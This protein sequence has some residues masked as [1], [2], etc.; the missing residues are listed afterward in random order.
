M[1]YWL[2][3]PIEEFTDKYKCKSQSTTI[4]KTEP[5]IKT[6]II[7]SGYGAA[8]AALAIAEELI[9][10]NSKDSDSPNKIKDKD[11]VVFEKGDEYVPGD[12]PKSMGELPGHL[13]ITVEDSNDSGLLKPGEEDVL[14]NS[15]LWDIRVGDGATSIAANGLGGTSLVNAGVAMDPD[16][17]I[18]ELWPKP[19][20]QKGTD[21]ENSSK[22]TG[23]D[24][25][26]TWPTLYNDHSAKI[27]T[28]LGVRENTDLEKTG[29]FKA[30]NKLVKAI[31]PGAQAKAAPLTINFEDNS[32]QSAK[33]TKCNL[34]GNCVMGCHSG[35]KGSL[36]LNAWPLARQ[37]GVELYTGAS[38]L[39][40][41]Q[42]NQE[43]TDNKK[44]WEITIEH[45]NNK[46]KTFVVHAQRI[47]LAAGTIGSTEILLR[48]KDDLRLSD[49]LGQR[50]STNGDALLFGVGQKEPV[51][52]VADIPKPGL[53]INKVGT[54]IT[55]VAK[56]DLTGLLEK[57]LKQSKK[58]DNSYKN[59]FSAIKKTI[60]LE[61]SAVPYALK[62]IWNEIIVTQSF[63]KRY[64][65]DKRSA[66][67]SEIEK[68][69]ADF[70][71]LAISNDLGRHSQV[72]L[73]MGHDEGDGILKAKK[74]NG[75]VT[76]S[77]NTTDKENNYYNALNKAFNSKTLETGFE[78]G[79][80]HPNIFWKP[81]PDGFDG[82]LEGGEKFKNQILTVHPLGGCC[83]GENAQEGVVN[84]K[85]QVFK[86][87]SGTEVYDNLYVLDGSIIPRPIGT[88]PF[89]TIATVS[90]ALASRIES[91]SESKLNKISQM[92]FPLLE[93]ET[94]ENFYDTPEKGYT[95]PDETQTNVDAYFKERMGR[96]FKGTSVD[97]ETIDLKNPL[98]E[99]D[100]FK[101]LGISEQKIKEIKN[102]E[103][104]KI[105][106][107]SNKQPKAS[108]FV[109][110][111]EFFYDDHTEQNNSLNKWLEH[112]GSALR[113]QAT[114]YLDMKESIQTWP[115]NHLLKL[116]KLQGEVTLG[117]LDKQ[118][119]FEKTKRALSVVINYVRMRPYDLAVVLREFFKEKVFSSKFK[120][121][122]YKE[123]KTKKNIIERAKGYWRVAKLHA[124]WRVMHYHFEHMPQISPT[125]NNELSELESK[126]SKLT[127]SGEK[128]L[129]FDCKSKNIWDALFYLPVKL[130][131]SDTGKEVDFDLRIDR[132]RI[133]KGPSPLQISKSLHSPNSL[134]AIF[135]MGSYFFRA[136]M[137]TYFWSFG[138][139]NYSTFKTKEDLE[140]PIGNSNSRLADP[141]NYIH[142]GMGSE[143]IVTKQL[144]EKSRKVEM[145]QTQVGP[146]RLLR[147][148]PKS[149]DP[150]R[151]SVLLIHGLAHSSRVFWT[152]S[153]RT[154]FIQYLLEK[155]YDVW[156]V[157][158]RV[159]ANLVKNV[160]PNDT[161]DNIA[162]IDLP[163]A[164]TTIF[165]EINRDI[166]KQSNPKKQV[167]VFAHCIGA[168]AISIAAL[169]GKLN[170]KDEYGDP[171]DESGVA[172]KN[173]IAN[174]GKKRLSM[175]ASLS[176][177]AVTP[178]F[179]A[180]TDNR[181]RANIWA[182]FKDRDL[183]KTIEPLP[184]KNP[185]FIEILY[186]RLATSFIKKEEL[187]EWCSLLFLGDSRG[188]GFARTIYK[189]Y[190]VFWGE[191]WNYKNVSLKTKKQFAGMIGPTPAT[192]VQQVLFSIKQQR[193][194][195]S[196][197]T[198]SYVTNKNLS[199][200]WNF[201]T[202][203][204]HGTHNKLFHIESTRLSAELLTK[205]R[206]CSA[207]KPPKD[208]VPLNKNDYLD[209]NVWIEIFNDYGHMDVIFGK[210]AYDEVFPKIENF[211]KCTGKN[212][213]TEGYQIPAL[214]DESFD[215]RLAKTNIRTKPHPITGPIISNPNRETNSV[216]TWIEA[217][218]FDTSG[219]LCAKVIS[220]N[221]ETN[222]SHSSVTAMT[223]KDEFSINISNKDDGFNI[224]STKLQQLYGRFYLY[225]HDN[226]DK[227]CNQDSSSTTILSEIPSD[228][229][230]A[231]GEKTKATQPKFEN[232][233]H[234]RIK[235]INNH[236]IINSKFKN[237]H[238]WHQLPWFKKTFLYKN[239]PP[240]NFP[241]SF[242]TGSCR[243][244]GATFERELS[245]KIFR[246]I[247]KHILGSEL[248]DNL[249]A[250]QKKKKA[251][252]VP[253]IDHVL[254]LG[255]QIYADSTANI[256]DPKVIYEKYRNRYRYAFNGRYS[257]HVFANVP[258]YF[259]IDDHEI[260]NNWS[261]GSYQHLTQTD[262][263]NKKIDIKMA[264]KEAM[265][266]QM[267]HEIN[268]N[269]ETDINI[270]IDT[271]NLSASK[272]D[273]I[274]SI[275]VVENQILNEGTKF[276]YNFKSVDRPFFVFDTRSQRNHKERNCYKAIVN[277]EQIEEF[278][279]WLEFNKDIKSSN[280]LFLASASP[281]S[282]FSKNFVK[283]ASVGQNFDTLLAYPGLI[284]KIINLL[285]THAKNK[286]IIWLT[287]DPH[288][289]SFAKLNLSCNNDHVDIYNICASGLFAP[290]P[291]ANSNS[292]DF[293]WNDEDK[294]KYPVKKI[295]PVNK[296][297][298]YLQ[299]IP[300]TGVNNNPENNSAAESITIKYQQYL[301]SN[302]PQHFI[303]IDLDA[304]NTELQLRAYNAGGDPFDATK[305][306][307]V[308]LNERPFFT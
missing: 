158:H 143:F 307:T 217:N 232:H 181:T 179:F 176:L 45:T 53:D 174:Q 17:E 149:D 169:A 308:D 168:G 65:T 152:D 277:E 252:T 220:N 255:D 293:D 273:T 32:K 223:S 245:D 127:L 13:N 183:I 292:H 44:I 161:W 285:S 192:I 250:E 182:I 198:N 133:T 8:M 238:I 58:S 290:F 265:N 267:H 85:G 173:D 172:F 84:T 274:T 298:F 242:I 211:I 270:G 81:L 128:V 164:V 106:Q 103:Y 137:Q 77:W 96:E 130:K 98:R 231:Q 91:E 251:T 295:I 69:K 72:L 194:T 156:I 208:S 93:K 12:F 55:G 171:L 30:L 304:D 104:K 135:G 43:E 89:M 281:I 3:K 196:Q 230:Q 160:N 300:E 225:N 150:E 18:F 247:W 66:W 165:N 71:P 148:Q 64:T 112:P 256:F 215:K 99:G 151:K 15:A 111:V 47:I 288:L 22:S 153:I 62:N 124:D 241:M 202:L 244:Q 219:P 67:H 41:N 216:G 184:H 82:V 305:Q 167:H 131:T 210:K 301:L 218:D 119:K 95:Y 80:Y 203:F 121:E 239:E 147:Y 78:G 108:G 227:L 287:G 178:W 155:N 195:D 49:Q 11:I 214:K 222:G 266:F 259:V 90:Y 303:R 110:D 38:V 204:T 268:K 61:N 21:S 28:L 284:K 201:P 162:L 226:V 115:T 136:F 19:F 185:S 221:P 40:L 74:G 73:A 7:G 299:C 306:I 249:S 234:F 92:A 296:Q 177:H 1:T 138:A 209:N 57:E 166:Q 191:Q 200:N 193:L 278:E 87:Q 86:G 122:N 205:F 116:G 60:T 29:K 145:I 134:M 52:A 302:S 107:N 269:Q 237:K 126:I 10:N 94:D 188:C 144:A 276:S 257:K 76:P 59:N 51:N 254:F 294:D 88:N 114:L 117:R 54:T 75:R 100:F 37:L 187:K 189:R 235:D 20:P 157:D 68:N 2:S 109:I 228:R 286:K 79:E 26:S 118:T 248:I 262:R 31:D 236:D 97:A 101:A 190:T 180:S 113:A 132:I 129:K 229:N 139:A 63:L 213:L 142:Y 102:D 175:I 280:I 105:S 291:F 154:N 199:E 283:H 70:D 56:I 5:G 258:S 34:C 146:C 289:S 240:I 42:I 4:C 35:A 83:M 224:D 186:D 163:W 170:Q 233:Q 261:G 263:H 264:F 125:E 9:A 246:D 243:H 33:Y 212:K 14:E 197:G 260:D 253:G 27:K 24:N 140:N 48:S 46:S 23:N 282:P 271:Q 275:P 159:S 297:E 141:P 123:N 50:F 272:P 6:L 25:H 279:T 39:H 36:N 120:K 16:A 206:L 207:D